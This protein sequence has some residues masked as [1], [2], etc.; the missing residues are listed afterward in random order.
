MS[1]D[2]SKRKM[3][4]YTSCWVCLATIFFHS[5]AADLK[6][7]DPVI[8]LDFASNEE[9]WALFNDKETLVIFLSNDDWTYKTYEESLSTIAEEYKVSTAQYLALV[10]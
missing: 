4:V 5:Q 7:K 1:T 3:N 2:Y 9:Q 6:S 10:L 8:N